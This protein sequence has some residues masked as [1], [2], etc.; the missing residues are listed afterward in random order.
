M[1]FSSDEECSDAMSTR[2]TLM[3]VGPKERR[4][5]IPNDSLHS[6]I[7]S[8]DIETSKGRTVVVLVH[9]APNS[10]SQS[11]VSEAISSFENPSEMFKQVQR[12]DPLLK[13][14]PTFYAKSGY[15]ILH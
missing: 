13:I 15:K 5:T 10:T 7:D 1:G 3:S 2:D 8:N 9:Q 11:D 4:A 12:Q 6:S 14:P